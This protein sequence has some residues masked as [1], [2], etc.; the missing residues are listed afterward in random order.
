MTKKKLMMMVV[1]VAVA[2]GAWAE[3][4]YRSLTQDGYTWCYRPVG[5]LGCAI[6][7]GRDYD[8]AI[9][10][11]PTGHLT[12]PE[13][14][15][16]YHDY[17]VVGIYGGIK[18]FISL[19]SISL[20]NTLEYIGSGAFNGCTNFT[21]ITIP[22]SVTTI[23]GAA[24]SGCNSLTSITIPNS[25]TDIGGSAFSGCSSLTSIT[26]P[27]SVTTIGGS[28]FSGCSSLQRIAVPSSVK[29]IPADCFYNCSSLSEVTLAE[30]VESIGSDAFANCRSL[31]RIV[32]PS[33]IKALN[34]SSGRVRVADGHYSNGGPFLNCINLE[35]VILIV[36][37]I[38]N[39]S[40]V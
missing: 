13:Y 39:V 35:E 38:D 22:N 14:L 6:G 16:G 31:H 37:D 32:L 18:T 9:W 21:S 28:A 1:A 15:R 24:F 20:P 12:I 17:K 25:V 3:T 30:G 8:Q 7:A 34:G 26:I 40:M 23:G 27:N 4:E 29:S 10:P 11:V 5:W 36:L 2:F 33:S 19:S